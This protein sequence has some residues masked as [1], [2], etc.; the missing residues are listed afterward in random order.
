M[1]CRPIPH[2]LRHLRHHPLF[3]GRRLVWLLPDYFEESLFSLNCGGKMFRNGIPLTCGGRRS[4]RSRCGSMVFR[5]CDWNWFILYSVLFNIVHQ[6]CCRSSVSYRVRS[7]LHGWE[8]Q[9]VKPC[10]NMFVQH[11]GH[12][13]RFLVIKHKLVWPL[14]VNAT[15]RRIWLFHAAVTPWSPAKYG[16]ATENVPRKEWMK[17]PLNE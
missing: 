7:G 5:H 17:R 11:I 3:P 12:C 15:S 10:E 16:P 13:L 2:T 1:P 9:V 8:S 6:C 14:V 4:R